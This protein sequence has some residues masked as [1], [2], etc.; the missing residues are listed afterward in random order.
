MRESKVK[1][2]T[3]SGKAHADELLACAMISIAMG[4]AVE[5][6]RTNSL[7]ED[8]NNEDFVVDFGGAYDGQRLFDHHQN[9]PEVAGE[10]AATLVAKKFF[11]ELLED[12]QWGPYLRRVTLQDNRGIKEVE[13]TRGQRLGDVL[14][15]EWGL[16]TLFEQD[17]NRVA[18]VVGEIISDRIKFLNEIKRA[19]EW[20]KNHTH[21]EV[22][23]TRTILVLDEDPRVEGV[24]PSAVNSATTQAL[25][26]NE[27]VATVS[28]DPRS[29]IGEVRTLFRTKAGENV[30]DFNRCKPENPTFCH[31]GGFLLNFKL[32]NPQEYLKLL[33]EALI[34]FHCGAFTMQELRG[35][36]LSGAGLDASAFTVDSKTLRS[37]MSEEK[38]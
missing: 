28:W 3:H 21:L 4:G 35:G 7:P 19:K 16:T 20:A 6:V 33:A 11:P 14:M 5:I 27:C 37:I 24:D 34:P 30:L 31:K 17:P 29:Q 1:I 38:L 12:D 25:I 2:I 15:L 22:V 8:L 36:D 9:T 10:C 23:G 26:K 18:A 32:G 13:A